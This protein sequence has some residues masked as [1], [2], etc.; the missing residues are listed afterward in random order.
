MPAPAHTHAVRAELELAGVE[1]DDGRRGRRPRRELE[2]LRTIPHDDA[3]PRER[4]KRAEGLAQL[5]ER[6]EGRVVI[7]LDVRQHR[8]VDAQA[9]HRSVGLV[10][11]DDEPLPRAPVRV[12]ETRARRAADQPRRLDARAAQRVHEHRRGRRLAMCP[13]DRDRAP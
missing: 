10:R 2:Q 7:E 9:Q 12:R 6:G 5:R 4:E 11:L 13:R 3:R 8:D 1:G